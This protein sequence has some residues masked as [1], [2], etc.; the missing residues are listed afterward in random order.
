MLRVAATWLLPDEEHAVATTA[1]DRLTNDQAVAPIL[2]WYEM[3][4][5]LIVNE[6]RGRLDSGKTDKALAC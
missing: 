3:R 5:L 6:R 2:W 1:F 4:N